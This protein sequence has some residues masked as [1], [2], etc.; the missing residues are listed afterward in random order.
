MRLSNKRRRRWT[1]L[2][3]SE[4]PLAKIES[5]EGNQIVLYR[6][7]VDGTEDKVDKRECSF[8]NK[9]K[10][11]KKD[12]SSSASNIRRSR[13][14]P[15]SVLK[16]FMLPKAIEKSELE[17]KIEKAC[18]DEFDVRH[19]RNKGRS[20]FAKRQFQ[21]NDFVLE[22]TG[23]LISREEGERREKI[24]DQDSTI[25]CFLT[26]FKYESKSYCLDSTIES[27]R[28]G[29]LVNHSKTKC[30]LE[31]RAVEIRER[32]CLLLFA[33]REIKSNDE[34]LYDYGDRNREALRSNPW[35]SK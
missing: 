34:L 21:R 5:D 11:R 10:F 8:Q 16:I 6:P 26:F 27:G 19:C 7:I 33:K 32:L 24:Y 15:T 18:E 25:G 35:L 14:L 20:V 17:V 23:E 31:L 4:L 30:N 29:R 3:I 1:G 9:K 2:S 22:L 12:K 13:R 28:L